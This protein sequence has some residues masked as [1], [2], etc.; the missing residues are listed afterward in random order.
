VSVEDPREDLGST[1]TS[2][3]PSELRACP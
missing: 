2:C 3:S 1:E